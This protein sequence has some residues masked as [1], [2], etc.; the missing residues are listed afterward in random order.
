MIKEFGDD[1]A[2]SNEIGHRDGE[3]AVGVALGRDF[4]GV[5]DHAPEY[6]VGEGRDAVDHHEWVADDEGLDGRGTAG[7]YGGAG[8]VE[9][10][11]GVGDEMDIWRCDVS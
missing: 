6:G 11:A 9:G 2:T 8:V 5:V 10:G 4:S 1:T 3:V 7:D